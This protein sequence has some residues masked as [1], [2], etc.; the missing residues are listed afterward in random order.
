MKNRKEETTTLG[1]R[2][3]GTKQRSDRRNGETTSRTCCPRF[4][5]I[6]HETQHG[7]SVW[8]RNVMSS[9]RV[10]QAIRSLKKLLS[11]RTARAVHWKKLSPDPFERL[12]LSTHAGKKVQ[13]IAH[14]FVQT[15][16]LNLHGMLLISLKLQKI[17]SRDFYY[18]IFLKLLFQ[19]LH[20]LDWY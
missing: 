20:F 1:R 13:K 19:I 16:F 4:V 8:K 12:G 3:D 5:C 17:I 7:L 15:I 10:T 14:K 6:D 2:D 18:C 9:V 11:A